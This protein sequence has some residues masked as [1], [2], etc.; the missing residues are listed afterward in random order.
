MSLSIHFQSCSFGKTTYSGKPN[1]D[2]FDSS[3]G[4]AQK[5]V[6]N[7]AQRGHFSKPE[8]GQTSQATCLEAQFYPDQSRRTAESGRSP[9]RD[10]PQDA[11]S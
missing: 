7:T 2:W 6:T 1:L 9:E 5:R 10:N 4:H 8:L 11:R 3:D